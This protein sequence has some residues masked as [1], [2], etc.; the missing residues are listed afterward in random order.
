MLNR[1]AIIKDIEVNKIIV[2]L[3]GFTQ[4]QLIDTVTAMSKG[5]VKLVEVKQHDRFNVIN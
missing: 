5:G 2:I 4:E 1:E 3:R